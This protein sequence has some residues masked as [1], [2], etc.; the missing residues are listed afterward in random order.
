[1]K[2][3]ASNFD[4]ESRG[5]IFEV[6]FGKAVPGNRDPLSLRINNGKISEYKDDEFSGIQRIYPTKEIKKDIDIVSRWLKGNNSVVIVGKEGCGK[7]LLL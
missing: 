7:S 1:M 3:L 4:S 2:G 5:T 6:V